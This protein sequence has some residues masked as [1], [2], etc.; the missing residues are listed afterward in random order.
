[1]L[2]LVLGR[3]GSGKTSTA[4]RLFRSKMDDGAAHL[5]FIVPEQYSHDAERQLLTICGDRLSLHGE[6][7]SFSRLCSRVFAELGGIGAKNLDSGGRLL[8]MSRA[9]DAVSGRLGIYSGMAQTPE[10]LEKLTAISK[11][12]KSACLTP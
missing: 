3:A 2:K 6:V 10:F 8:L 12:F 1:M 7:L 4:M 5:Y 11:E 9:V